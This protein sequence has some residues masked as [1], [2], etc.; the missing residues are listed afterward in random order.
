M[1]TKWVDSLYNSMSLEQKIGQLFMPFIPSDNT[2]QN[3][4]DIKYLIDSL[5]VGNFFFLKGHPQDEQQLNNFVQLQS[6]Y[7]VITAIDAEWGLAMRLDSTPRFPW[8]MTLGAIQNDSIIYQIARRIG[9]HTRAVGFQMNFSPVIDIN[10]NPDNPIIG[11]RSFGEDKDNVSRKGFMMMKGLQDENILTTAKHFPGHGDTSQDSHKTLPSVNFDYNRIQKVELYPYK[12]LIPKGLTGIMVAHL[13][14]PSV[15]FMGLP[16]TLSY[17]VATNLLKEQ[18]Q[19]SGLIITDAMNMKGV[20]NYA[21]SGVADLQ[22]FLAGNDILLGT[23]EMK[24]ATT[25]FKNAYQKG[26]ISEERLAYSVKKILKAKYWA[27]LEQWKPAETQNYYP[28]VKDSVLNQI[29]YENAI[30]LIKNEKNILP[31]K[32]V[33]QKIAYVQIGNASAATFYKYLNKYT[34]VDKIYIHNSKEIEQKLKDYDLVIIGYHKSSATPWKTFKFS[35]SEKKLLKQ[36][37]QEK[38]SIVDI[39]TSPYALINI[40]DDLQAKAII[41]SY[42]N[43]WYPQ[44]ISPQM[45]FGALDF[46]GKLPVSISKKFTVNTGISTHNIQ[47]LSYGF[48]EQVGMNSYKL[49]RVDSLMQFM[50]D[51]LASPGGVVLA[52]RKGKVIFEK[53]YGYQTY[54]KKRKVETT[55]LYDLASVTKVMAATTLMMKAYDMKMYRLDDKLGKLMPLLKGS[56]K[57][58]ITV[59]EALSHYAKIKSWIPFYIETLDKRKKPMKKFYQNKYSPEFSIEVAKNLYLKNDY[60]NHLWDTI[61][62]VP[63]YEKLKYVYSGLPFYLFRKYIDDNLHKRMDQVLNEEFYKPIGANTVTFRP[64]E[65]FLP[66][67]IAPS[68]KD[69]Y[70]RHQILRGYVHDMGAAM[71]NG[72]SGNAGLFGNAND[73]AKLMQMHLNEGIYGAK[74]YISSATERKFNHRYFAKDSVRRGLGWDKP[75]FKGKPGPT[76]EEISAKSFGHQGFTGTMVWA[77]PEEEIVYIFLSN[78]TYPTMKNKLMYKLNFRSEVHRRIYEAIIN[79]KHDYHNHSTIDP[80]EYWKKKEKN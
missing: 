3:K 8:N 36:I 45:I 74:R 27:S 21:P 25:D 10:T 28:T 5:Y 22:A 56:N 46:K 79:P 75:Q 72:V 47:R 55:D 57:D 63:Q 78:R 48:P 33:A 1:Q 34:Q 37:C 38:P 41:I 65:K 18:L 14:I 43:D 40:A 62:S 32:N 42:Q 77:D 39:F 19:Y 53:A 31:I 51:T 23:V 20:A 6:K 15:E 9:K 49:K 24:K 70:Y 26:I 30:T 52:A 71:L 80:Y 59:K 61:A 16:T 17:R 50:M 64:L 13:N 11:N 44:V 73:L 12:Q 58:T 35:S 60:L 76:F 69:T 66:E 7:P 4:A 29:A 67:R 54:D 68:E 2:A